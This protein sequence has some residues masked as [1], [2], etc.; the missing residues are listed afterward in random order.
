M[1]WL[2]GG[3]RH[4][5]TGDVGHRARVKAAACAQALPERTRHG[6]QG[7][8]LHAD[9]YYKS[10]GRRER[11]V[12]LCHDVDVR[13]LTFE[14]YMNKKLVSA[15]PLAHLKIGFKNVQHLMGFVPPEY[16]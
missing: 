12:S 13:K 7:A 8:A 6:L 9:A 4:G 2:A 3:C 1:P 11:F 16:V 15:R 5:G 14:A 10:D